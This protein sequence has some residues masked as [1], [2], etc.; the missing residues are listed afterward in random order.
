MTR[1]QKTAAKKTATPA[2]KTTAARA[3]RTRKTTAA[4][5]TAPPRLSL[6]KPIPDLPTRTSDFMTDAQ[7]YATHHARGAG[8]PIHRIRDWSNQRNGAATRRL[9]DGSHL[10]YNHTTRTLTWHE[11]CPMGAP[12]QYVITTPSSVSAARVDV[13]RCQT[14]HADLSTIPP[15]TPDELAELGL[16]H[17]PTWAQ[18]VPGD[19]PIT[20][21]I[22]VAD[23]QTDPEPEPRALA[24]EL[25]HSGNGVADTQPMSEAAI[26]A[27]IAAQ[28]AD[29]TPK[30]HPEP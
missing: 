27:H 26:A 8:L 23:P 6:V 25:A 28:L 12:H 20:Q 30:E 22:T 21:T 29:Q 15:L 4:R 7:I 17:T 10:H 24:D 14:P 5:K 9:P 11:R 13:A 16:L 19:T 1:A 3:P 2:K 18:T